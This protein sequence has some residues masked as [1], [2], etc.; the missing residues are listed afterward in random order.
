MNCRHLRLN[1]RSC[2]PDGPNRSSNGQGPSG[3]RPQT[4]KRDRGRSDL[5]VAQ[6]K[7]A[8]QRAARRRCPGRHP[9]PYCR[10]FEYRPVKQM[11]AALFRVMSCLAF[12]SRRLNYELLGEPFSRRIRRNWSLLPFGGRSSHRHLCQRG[13]TRPQ[14]QTRCRKR[15]ATGLWANSKTARDSYRY[16]ANM[17]KRLFR[18]QPTQRDVN[19]PQ[20]ECLSK[21]F[22]LPR[23]PKWIG[24]TRL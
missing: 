2:R 21:S 3:H 14:R 1:R 19:M 18:F 6:T 24:K 11:W 17:A 5:E 12:A 4:Q 16:T 7:I 20:R 9:K 10:R 15:S 22:L 23:E 13:C 8:P